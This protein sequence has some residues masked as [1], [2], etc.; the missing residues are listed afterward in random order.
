MIIPSSFKDFALVPAAKEES[1]SDEEEESSED[2]HEDVVRP[3]ETWGWIGGG[4][5]GMGILEP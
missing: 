3:C 5:G 4:G 2:E 1:S